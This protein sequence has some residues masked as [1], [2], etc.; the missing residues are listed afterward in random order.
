MVTVFVSAGTPA[1]DVQEKFLSVVINAI[2]LAGLTP[3]LM[4]RR[5]WNF[6]NPLRG[7]YRV[8]EECCGVVVVAYA[9]YRI[10]SGEELRRDGAKGLRDVAFP[11][12]WNQIEAAMAY[13]KQMPLLVI[14]QKG[15]QADAVLESTGDTRPFWTQIDEDI[16]L[17]EGFIGYL[18]VLV[19]FTP[20]CDRMCREADLA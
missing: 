7:I 4:S 12:A 10:T 20:P 13:Q 3:R 16:R 9:R 6:I 8:M 2:E 11:T 18:N 19:R 17:D 15:L 1:D 14:A 5:D